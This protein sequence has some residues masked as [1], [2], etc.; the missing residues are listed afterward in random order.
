MVR[1]AHLL[2]DPI[3]SCNRTLTLRANDNRFRLIRPDTR[4]FQPFMQSSFTEQNS[5]VVSNNSGILKANPTV[6][7]TTTTD[8]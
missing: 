8:F 3:K 4:Y 2:G 7:F 6:V 1:L 5:Y